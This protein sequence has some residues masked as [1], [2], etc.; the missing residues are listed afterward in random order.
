MWALQFTTRCALV[1][2]RTRKSMVGPTVVPAG[3]GNFILWDSHCDNL[4]VW[5]HL[6]KAGPRE[7]RALVERSLGFRTYPSACRDVLLELAR[8]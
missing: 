8:T 7:F 5:I 1:R 6:S 2:V 3:F 4:G